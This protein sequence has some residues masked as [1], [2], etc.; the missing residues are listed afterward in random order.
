MNKEEFL[1]KL[2]SLLEDIPQKERED[3]IQYYNDYFDDA[4]EDRFDEVV[5]SLGSP[6]KVAELIKNESSDP[7]AVTKEKTNEVIMTDDTP[8]FTPP[9]FPEPA[10]TAQPVPP[11]VKKSGSKAAVIIAC[12]LL[13][14]GV[15]FVAFGTLFLGKFFRNGGPLK[16]D[17]NI[18]LDEDIT[19]LHADFT[20]RF[21]EIS[22]SSEASDHSWSFDASDVDS[23]KIIAGASE[24]RF[25]EHKENTIDVSAHVTG[26]VICTAE[27]GVFRLDASGLDK[28]TIELGNIKNS[29]TITLPSGFRTDSAE[30]SLGAG[31]FSAD[32]LLADTV[33]F[34]VGAGELEIDEV[35]GDTVS[36]SL[37]AGEV[38]IRKMSSETSHLSVNAGSI[39]ISKLDTGDLTAAVDMGEIDIDLTGKKDDYNYR[40]SCGMGEINIDDDEYAGMGLEKK[41]DNNAG[42]NVS[43]SCS[44]GEIE[45]DF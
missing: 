4:G 15:L 18:D 7:I 17:Y 26:E 27:N 24:I 44:M 35:A 40:L 2:A 29:I 20:G 22:I 5:E 23:I 25:M 37:N 45:I 9:P 28:G 3:A 8:K 21:P 32:T 30:I 42:R 38:R 16:F 34:A 6:E 12:I 39:N 33:T 13:G 31:S 19:G 1:T 43:L 41:I 36:V 11:P 10:Y 14:L